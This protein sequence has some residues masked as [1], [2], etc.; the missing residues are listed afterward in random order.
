MAASP[1]PDPVPVL[2]ARLLRWYDVHQRDLP[3]RRSR[4]SYRIWVSEIML[5]QTRV[6]AVI[7][8]YERFLKRFPTLV[9]L[10]RAPLEEV[11][12]QWSG[13]GYYRRARM[14]HA[15]AQQVCESGASEL[16]ESRSAILKL[17]GIGRYTAGA[18]LSMAYG[19]PEPVL[20]GNVMRVLS[21]WFAIPGDP[22]KAAV[23]RA[24]WS[25]AEELVRCERPGDLNQA[26]ME[27]GA[28]LCLPGRAARCG[29]CP[30]RERCEAARRDQVSRFPEL[31]ARKEPRT[32]TWAV[33][34]AL[35]RG[36]HLV[37][38]RPDEALLG[39]LW[40]LP[41]VP[42]VGAES[43][44]RGLRRVLRQR[45]SRTL[46]VG[47]PLGS[48]QQVISGRRIRFEVFTLTPPPGRLRGASWLNAT[49]LSQRP[50]TTATHRILERL[51]TRP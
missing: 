3:W 38:R 34:H 39:G 11:L 51:A 4:Q 49:E 24:L 35:R 12:L 2:R 40:E 7:P 48:Y 36:R 37:W 27:L 42:I 15:T 46:D 30:V 29:E 10:A 16:P 6:E 5:Q 20:D 18:I 43:P 1:H 45:L 14:L 41:S 26:L 21:R 13:L 22:K 32:E 23:A 8:Y 50:L 17:P 47:S 25:R 44:A 28:L 19:Q 31:A 33:G 9:D